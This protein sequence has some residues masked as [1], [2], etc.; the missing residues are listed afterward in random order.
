[1]ADIRI[2]LEP[3]VNGECTFYPGDTIKGLKLKNK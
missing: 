1:M 3:N 2:K